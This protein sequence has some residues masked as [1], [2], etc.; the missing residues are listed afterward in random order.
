MTT[1]C[2]PQ[3]LGIVLLSLLMPCTES[4]AQGT[5]GE[6]ATI[7]SRFLIDLPSAGVLSHGTMALDLDFYQS[8]GL[9]TSVS[10]G[11]FSRLLLG[12]SFGGAG[13]IGS[14]HIY[15][16]GSPGVTARLRVL[17]ETFMLPAFALGFDSQ[18]KEKYVEPLHRYTIKS[19]GFYGVASKNYRVAGY[20]ALHGG[21]NYSFEQD[22]GDADINVFAGAEKTLGSFLSFLAEYNL[23]MNDSNRDALGR[24]RGY[25][26]VGFMASLGGG[27]MLGFNLKDI[28]KNQDGV[29]IGNRTVRLEY[30]NHP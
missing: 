19:L 3:I 15:W 27:L 9:L 21:V 1:K 29:A 26:N 30:V 6:K 18:G 5:A 28:I 16:N 11:V 13:L 8:G 22:D 17:D 24:G 4:V 10:V 14:D 12:I 25:L 2:P 7:E 23:G 20:L